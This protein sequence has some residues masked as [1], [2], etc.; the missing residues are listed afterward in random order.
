MPPTPKIPKSALKRE[1]KFA[2]ASPISRITADAP[3]F[4]VLHG[5]NDTLIPV[6]QGAQ[7]LDML[8]LLLDKQVASGDFATTVRAALADRVVTANENADI[9]SKA[10]AL[11]ANLNAIVRELD[12]AYRAH[13][14]SPESP[15]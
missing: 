5:T 7:G 1:K 8:G 14:P 10:V 12:A 15:L 11:I 2:A 3:P 6:G 9:R 13:V 4:F